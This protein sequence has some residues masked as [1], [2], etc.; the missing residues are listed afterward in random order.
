MGRCVNQLS[1][2]AWAGASLCIKETVASKEFLLVC[3][4]KVKVMMVVIT[5]TLKSDNEFLKGSNRLWLLNK[6]IDPN[7]RSG[8]V[9][10]GDQFSLVFTKWFTLLL[11]WAPIDSFSQEEAVLSIII[12]Q[13]AAKTIEERDPLSP[14]L[15]NVLGP[16]FP[17]LC[18]GGT[19]CPGS[20]E[21]ER[22]SGRF[23]SS[24]LSQSA[25]KTSRLH[26]HCIM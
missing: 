15:L 21:V 23:G 16:S 1:H 22:C 5:T 11:L 25:L 12:K 18:S 4:S 7:G 3:H 20:S 6:A 19:F 24:L 2:L 8:E 13:K 10:I 9:I 26:P 14:V 17:S